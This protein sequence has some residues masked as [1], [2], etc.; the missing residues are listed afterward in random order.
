MA[1]GIVIVNYLNESVFVGIIVAWLSSLE[2]RIAEW[3]S[4]LVLY[5]YKEC[6][7]TN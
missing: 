2:E 3:M 7:S 1:V 5:R 6:V 4:S